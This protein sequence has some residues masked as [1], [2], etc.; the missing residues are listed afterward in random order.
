MTIEHVLAVVPV[1]D[2]EIARR[3]YERLLGRPPDNHPMSTL[4]EWRVTE[5]GWSHVTVDADR[6]GTALSKFAVDDLGAHVA[7]LRERE[8][9]GGPI[10]DVK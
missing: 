6:A 5:T 8:F 1:A 10:Q 3:W 7:G 9:A 4:M 2:I